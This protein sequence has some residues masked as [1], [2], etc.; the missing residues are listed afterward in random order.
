MYHVTLFILIGKQS[1]SQMQEGIVMA[2]LV[3]CITC[4]FHCELNFLDYSIKSKEGNVMEKKGANNSISFHVKVFIFT[5]IIRHYLFCAMYYTTIYYILYNT[6]NVKYLKTCN[7]F[8]S[9]LYMKC[10]HCD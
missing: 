2:F 9:D 6:I 1:T 7:G 10:F 4:F 3:I 8:L 5:D